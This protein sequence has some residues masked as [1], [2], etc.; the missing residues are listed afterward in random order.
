[1]KSLRP[2]GLETRREQSSREWSWDS[3]QGGWGPPTT[4]LPRLP[5]PEAPAWEHLDVIKERRDRGYRMVSSHSTEVKTG[6][7]T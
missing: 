2:Q 7:S 5:E 1:M 6:S 4:I 3:S